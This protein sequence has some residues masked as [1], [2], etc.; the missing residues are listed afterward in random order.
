MTKSIRIAIIGAGLIGPR[1]AQAVQKCESAELIA[2]VDPAPSGPDTAAHFS[3]PCYTSVQ[4]MLS[5]LS[6][7]ERPDAAIV[8]T[9]NHNHVATSNE[10]LAANV[11]VLVEKPICTVTK[12]GEALV[13]YAEQQGLKLL[14]GHHRRFNPYIIAAKRALDSNSI[15]EVIAVNGLWTLKKADAYF[16]A[17]TAWRADKESG[18]VVR[19]NLVHEVDILQHLLGPIIGVSAEKTQSHR[20]NEAEE[21]AAILMKFASGV[22]GTFL[23]S[24][25]T[26]SGHNFESGTGENPMIPKSGLDFYRIFGTEGSLSVPDM[27]ISKCGDWTQKLES[28][29]SEVE[30][31]VPFESQVAHFVRVIKGE[32]EP[33]CS[34]QEGLRAVKVCEA[35]L[36]SLGK[37]S[38]TPVN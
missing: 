29:R 10:L 8:C 35:I 24:D 6:P 31:S 30:L 37:D 34:G 3:V 1:H 2:F 13:Q 15:G 23:L 9:P 26:P 16:K 4:Q 32:E 21:G 7:T 11:H 17:P 12:E 22:V 18:G 14:V 33:S 38:L 28:R 5:S 36:E 25:N 19:I 27:T 20:G